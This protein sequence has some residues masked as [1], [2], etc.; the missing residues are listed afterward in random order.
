MNAPTCSASASP[1][2]SSRAPANSAA[3]TLPDAVPHPWKRNGVP[4]PGRE[5]E[6]GPP[7]VPETVPQITFQTIRT[8]MNSGTI[9][10]M[11]NSATPAP[12]GFELGYARPSTTKQSLAPQLDAFSAQGIPRAPIFFDRK[13]GAT[14]NSA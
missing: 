4:G 12:S 1:L 3:A 8:E 6:N 13:T 10:G 2:N 5:R 14:T 11:G 9:C 7:P